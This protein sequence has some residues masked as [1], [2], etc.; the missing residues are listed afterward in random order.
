MLLR[1]RCG[2][3][4][5]MLKFSRWILDHRRLILAIFIVL[6]VLSAWLATR[7]KIDFDL[8]HYVPDD[9]ESTRAM[10]AVLS[11]FDEG[12]PNLRLMK[13]Q[14][15][16]ADALSLKEKLLE[17]PEVTSVRWLDDMADPASPIE[18]L[19]PQIVERFY[20]DGN[21]LFLLTVQTDDYR[22]ALEKIRRVAGD[23]VAL[24]GTAV[25]LASADK[26]VTEEMATILKI[27]VPGA[28]LILLL[29]TSSWFEPVLFML[30]IMS[31]VLL[32]MGSNVFLGPISFITQSVGAVLQLALSMDYSIFLLNRFGD[33]RRAGDDVETAM[34]KAISS[35]FSTIS[36]SALTTVFGFLS[37]TLMRFKIGP[38]LGVV[39][40]KGIFFSL[41][42]VIF[43]LPALTMMTL[44]WVDKTTHRPLIPKSDALKKMGAFVIRIGIPILIVVLITMV[45]LFRAMQANHFS[46]GSGN[47]PT[48]SREDQ[49]RQRIQRVYGERQQAVLLV[50]TGNPAAEEALAKEIKA[51]PQVLSLLSYSETVGNQIPAEIVPN[52]EIQLLKSDQYSRMI[53]EL[54]LPTESKLT[55]ETAEKLRE[56]ASVYYP[57]E[58]LWAGEIFAMLDMR[59]T[60]RADNII[61]NG[62]AILAVGLVLLFN[63]RSLS[64]PAIL[65][66]NIEYAIWC[67]FAILYFQGVQLNFIGYLVIST[68][69]LG[70]T[71]DYAI[72]LTEHYRSCRLSLPP[73]EAAAEALARSI[74][75]IVPPACILSMAGFT[76]NSLSS[77]TVV[78]QI[79]LVLGSG[80]LLSLATVIFL[81]PNL[82][83][84]SDPLIR[85]TSLGFKAK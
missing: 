18:T 15:A 70:A 81:L 66:F 72:L 61:V 20:K 1:R 29:V 44:K 2:S 21:A 37:L 73:K 84:F 30:T 17:L 28:F 78:S 42:T 40:A 25:S 22:H 55:F 77:L 36:S 59:D 64:L 9:A 62:L 74:P 26:S 8:S 71:V 65:V 83:R 10:K 41:V 16:I 31:G 75:A 53:V 47:F 45:P 23:G 67:N 49:D 32:N 80:A 3:G 58:S 79:G 6:L 51:L 54:N 14:V 33:Y 4:G 11:E 34:S 50:P 5:L 24:D 57:Q 46:Y 19:D 39:L 52:Q 13:G 38:D 82:L 68:I 35:A 85:V 63:F 43:L 60:V 7:V 69:Q 27:S 56:I 12:V 48:H 76:L